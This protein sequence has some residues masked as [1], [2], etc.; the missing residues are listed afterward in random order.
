[1]PGFA[2]RQRQLWGGGGR[3]RR[4]AAQGTHSPN[5]PNA[6]HDS[7]GDVRVC[8]CVCK[9]RTTAF[10]Y[11]VIA[12]LS[13]SAAPEEEPA[14]LEAMVCGGR[15]FGAVPTLRVERVGTRL[16]DLLRT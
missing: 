10:A 12:C 13:R 4:A 8:V 15:A 11:L 9:E 5:S 14:V 2:K 6:P 1:M 16:L 7:A 3:R